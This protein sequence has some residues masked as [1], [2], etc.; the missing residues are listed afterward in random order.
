M[1]ESSSEPKSARALPAVSVPLLRMFHFIVRGYFRRH[2]TAVR[3]R[4]PRELLQQPRSLA[5]RDSGA[6]PSGMANSLAGPLIIYANHGSWWDPMVSFLLADALLPGRRHFAPMDASA[7]AKYKVL[8]KLGIFPVDMHTARGAA[9]FLRTGEAV[10]RAGG[11]LWITPQG[12]FADARERPLLFKPGIASLVARVPGTTVLPLAIEYPFWD[13]RLPE[14]LLEL[15]T[16]LID[17]PR[18]RDAA[19]TELIAAL[20]HTMDSLASAVQLRSPAAF[21][22]T[23]LRGRLGTGGFY[24]LAQRAR[25]VVLRRPYQPAHNPQAANHTAA[26]EPRP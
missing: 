7:L 3:L 16:P 13:E 2:F 21:Q 1:P 19:Q 25:A 22:R 26:A 11:V 14:A 9:Q 17:L 20:T 23:L 12:R 18:D 24:A 4:G 15:G 5:P 8:S 10:L 6:L